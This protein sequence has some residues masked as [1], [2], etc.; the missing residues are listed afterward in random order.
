MVHLPFYRIR[1]TKYYQRFMR[2]QLGLSCLVV[3]IAAWIIQSVR[4]MISCTVS[5]FRS[6]NCI[7]IRAIMSI[8]A[9]SVLT[10]GEK[11]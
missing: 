4:A 1:K 2:T 9:D 10:N 3:C 8:G 6:F 7:L 11:V 5:M